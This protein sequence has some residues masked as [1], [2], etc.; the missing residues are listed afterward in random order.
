[1]FKRIPVDKERQAWNILL[2]KLSKM[3]LSSEPV[4]SHYLT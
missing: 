4:G 2:D 1:M 3:Y